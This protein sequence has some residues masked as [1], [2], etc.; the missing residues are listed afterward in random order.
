[1][2]AV[3]EGCEGPLGFVDFLG[4]IANQLVRSL[5]CTVQHVTEAEAHRVQFKA[6]EFSNFK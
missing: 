5:P 2:W 3:Q 4:T 1:M 6:A